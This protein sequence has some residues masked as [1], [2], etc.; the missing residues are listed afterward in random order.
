[1]NSENKKIAIY[2]GYFHHFRLIRTMHNRA[3]A[4]L[5]DEFALRTTLPVGFTRFESH[6]YILHDIYECKD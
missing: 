6:E 3:W 1:M 5:I 2:I 4:L